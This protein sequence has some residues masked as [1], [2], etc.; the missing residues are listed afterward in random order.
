[1]DYAI[2]KIFNMTLNCD[3]ETYML[4]LKTIAFH[5]LALRYVTFFVPVDTLNTFLFLVSSETTIV[6]L[7]S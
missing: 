4:I 2:S 5:I 7:S 3:N 1:M 6:K